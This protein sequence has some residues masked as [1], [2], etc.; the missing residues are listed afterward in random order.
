MEHIELSTSPGGNEP[1]Q[2]VCDKPRN[3]V[4]VAAAELAAKVDTLFATNVERKS[5]ITRCVIISNSRKMRKISSVICHA[6]VV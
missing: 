5:I 3:G 4:G 6:S 2:A 1:K